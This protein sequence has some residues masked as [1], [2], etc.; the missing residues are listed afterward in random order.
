VPERKPIILLTRVLFSAVLL[1][2]LLAPVGWAHDEA[3]APARGII[4][5]IG[6][7]MGD[8]Q[9]TAARWFS[10]GADGLLNMDR[11]AI[12]DGW[13]MTDSA[14]GLT[15]D[16]AAA[17]TAIASGVKT[18]NG[19]VGRDL[20]FADVATI[21]E[22][23]QAAGGAVG[24]VTTAPITHATPA[25]FA[26]HVSH[27]DRTAEI[28]E[29]MISAQVDLLLG[30]GEVDSL[31]VGVSGIHSVGG[32]RRD[33]VNLIEKATSAGYRI[34]YSSEDL[35]VLD[36]SAREPILGLF[37][38]GG[39]DWPFSPTLAEMTRT[40]IDTLDGRSDGFFLMVEAGQID[41]V[42]HGNDTPGAIDTTLSFDAAIGVA[43]DYVEQAG[44]VLLIVTADHE[45]GGMSVTRASTG[46][47]REDGP[48]AMPDG[49]PFFVNWTT[50]SHTNTNVPVLAHGPG[51]GVL[52][53]IYENTWVF[54]AMIS[55]LGLPD[56]REDAP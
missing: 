11:L 34:V 24:L 6:D 38:S 31:P 44:D 19:V 51:A 52:S 12:Q 35:G 47:P 40:A 20:A 16:S 21:L 46:M 39:L 49:T 30:G 29:Q 4:L 54:D 13:A 48:F 3:A 56:P 15:T 1:L 45:T 33:G 27:R 10:I 37:A 17:A 14:L 18:L 36:A 7:G 53:G 43:L 2:A 41:W 9:R 23:A 22:L 32:F 42:C 28:A 8:A 25:A 26:A 50:G 55:A 5:M